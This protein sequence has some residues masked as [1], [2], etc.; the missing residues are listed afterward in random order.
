[1]KSSARKASNAVVLREAAENPI[2]EACDRR[3]LL[4]HEIS[5][6]PFATSL[7]ELESKQ[8]SCSL[9]EKS[10]GPQSERHG[11]P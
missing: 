10:R 3:A 4:R 7:A 8:M 5:Q 9:V 6:P 11:S 2:T 1:M